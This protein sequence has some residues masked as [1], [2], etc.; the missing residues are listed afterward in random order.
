MANGTVQVNYWNNQTWHISEEPMMLGKVYANFTSIGMFQAE[1]IMFY[2]L[3]NE[4]EIHS[5]KVDRRDPLSW[6]Y[7]EMVKTS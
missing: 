5:Y 2:G 1:D 3:T 4:G 7:G 6:S